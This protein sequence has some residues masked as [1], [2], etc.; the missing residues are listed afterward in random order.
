LM[1]NVGVDVHGFKP[2]SLDQI[3]AIVKAN[4]AP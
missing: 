1:I 4:G 3:I 2:V